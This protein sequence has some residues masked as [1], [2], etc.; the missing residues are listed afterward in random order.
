[1]LRITNVQHFLNPALQ[2]GDVCQIGAPVENCMNPS[3]IT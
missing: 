2:L 1:M 3:S